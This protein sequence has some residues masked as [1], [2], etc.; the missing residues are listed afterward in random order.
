MIALRAINWRSIGSGEEEMYK[1]LFLSTV[2]R[3]ITTLDDDAVTAL[4][5]SALAIMYGIPRQAIGS[6]PEPH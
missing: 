6:M 3:T 2:G 4:G 1:E 5:R